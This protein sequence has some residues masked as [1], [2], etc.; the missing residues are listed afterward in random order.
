[1]PHGLQRSNSKRM[2]VFFLWKMIV[3]KMEKLVS[4]I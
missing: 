3:I 2:V 4:I 1:M